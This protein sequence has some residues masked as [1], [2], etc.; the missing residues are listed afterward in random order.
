MSEG[1]VRLG[2]KRKCGES[3]GINGQIGRKGSER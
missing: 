1:K 2:E 3:V